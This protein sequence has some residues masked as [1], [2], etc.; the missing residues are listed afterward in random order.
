MGKEKYIFE[1][2]EILINKKNIIL[3]IIQN[4]TGLVYSQPYRARL[5]GHPV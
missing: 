5:L 2:L 4:P 3:V 1:Y